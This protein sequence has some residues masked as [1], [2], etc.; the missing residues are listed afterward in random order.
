MFAQNSPTAFHRSLDGCSSSPVNRDMVHCRGLIASH[1]ENFRAH[2]AHTN[3]KKGGWL[4]TPTHVMDAVVRSPSSGSFSVAAR[5]QHE[6]RSDLQIRG[7]DR[8]GVVWVAEPRP[9]GIG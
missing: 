5:R 1:S 2:L 8:D 6:K 3:R 4:H 7:I 9:V